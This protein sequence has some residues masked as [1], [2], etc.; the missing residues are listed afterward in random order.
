MCSTCLQLRLMGHG[1]YTAI[2]CV[3]S[4]SH[5]TVDT[6]DNTKAKVGANLSITNPE[7]HK[8]PPMQLD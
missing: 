3:N 8:T 4:A 5:S 2:L 6:Q 1:S 7:E